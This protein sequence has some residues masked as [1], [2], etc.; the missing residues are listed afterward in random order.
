MVV[1][2]RERWAAVGLAAMMLLSACAPTVPTSGDG[3]ARA[4]TAR[5][6]GS[7]AP[8]V[9]VRTATFPDLSVAALQNNRLPGSVDND[10]GL[11]LG[12]V[13]S[14]LWR[15][16]ADPPDEFW[17][18]TD[19]GPNGQVR[20]NGKNR[21]T[22]PLP[23]YTPAIV[24]VRVD[25]SSVQILD[26]VP[27][28]GR[29]GRPVTGLPNV[30]GR[31]EIPFDFS[32]QVQL[33]HN[34][35]GLDIEGLVRTAAGDFWLADEYGPSLVHVDA[36]GTV[37]ARYVPEGHRI[38]GA[39][40]PVIEVLPALY[41]R[42]SDNRG[43]E[44]LTAS[45]DGS[46]L[47]LALQSPLAHPDK[48]TGERS[49]NVRILAFDVASQRPTAE[50]V[51]RF[52]P[53]AEFDPTVKPAPEEMKISGLAMAGPHQLL[54]LE[55]TDHVAKLYLADLSQATNIL[56]TPWNLPATE[57][58]LEATGNLGTVG[59][60]PVAKTLAVDLATVPNVPDKIEGIAIVDRTTV[61]I[62]NDNDFDIGN[63]DRDGNNVGQGL[64]SH[65]LMVT[66]PRPLP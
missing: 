4:T 33:P 43:F 32:A 26:T 22:F 28:V 8:G 42:R 60:T 62:A 9:L 13:G 39:D 49:R 57:P 58:S 50:Y 6:A 25:G 24:R 59:V 1:G 37:L 35:S 2:A 34:P 38:V 16:P 17:M 23:D 63:F 54:V 48:K 36:A 29:S 19:R 30:E 7:L 10:R 40:Y 21:R 14:D 51:Y 41:A 15:S 56:N 11:L 45:Q 47:Y 31:D 20:A 61:A 44:G 18:V 46:T 66:L 5:E 64:K 3:G 27:L 52:E 65:L 53:V 12:G 55:R